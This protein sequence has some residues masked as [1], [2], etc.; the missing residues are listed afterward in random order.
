MAGTVNEAHMTRLE[1][2][3]GANDENEHNGAAV[4]AP[5]TIFVFLEE[6]PEILRQR[7]F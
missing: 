1:K 3:H 5:R 2:R 4:P 7:F 6:S